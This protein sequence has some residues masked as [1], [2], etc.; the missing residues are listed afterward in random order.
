MT[1]T[2]IRYPNQR[3][4]EV[5]VTGP[6]EPAENLTASSTGFGWRCEG[7][8]DTNPSYMNWTIRDARKAADEHAK[9]CT[10]LPP[11]TTKGVDGPHLLAGTIGGVEVLIET[12]PE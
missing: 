3:G 11:A 8:H 5:H 12:V 10:A 6:D 4:A 7:C 2:G 1:D 9:Q